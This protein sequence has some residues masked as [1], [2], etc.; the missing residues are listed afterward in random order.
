MGLARRRLCEPHASITSS[1]LARTAAVLPAPI[2]PSLSQ[3]LKALASAVR[4]YY[5]TVAPAHAT[6]FLALME[7][8]IAEKE[9]T[10]LPCPRACV[11][12]P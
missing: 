10:V 3:A 12:L 6:Q 11:V 8:F 9:E 2:L 5:L 4:V 7:T 1:I